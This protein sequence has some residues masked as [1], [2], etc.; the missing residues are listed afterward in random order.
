MLAAASERQLTDQS[1]VAEAQSGSA[2]AFEILVQRYHP[3]LLRYLTRQ[4]GDREL[5]P[6]RPFLTPSATSSGSRTIS[7]S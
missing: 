1:L 7:P 6:R 2:R 5:G 3:Q 4:V